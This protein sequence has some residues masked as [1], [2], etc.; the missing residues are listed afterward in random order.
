MSSSAWNVPGGNAPNEPEIV[1]GRVVSANIPRRELRIAPETSHPERFRELRVIRLKSTAGQIVSLQ[2]VGVRISKKTVIAHVR[3]DDEQQLAA[4]RGTL[5][6]VPCSERF[7]LPENEY[8]ID[9]LLG[10]TIRDT[11]G[12]VI[13]KLS[14]IW[15]TPAND[16]YQV[17]DDTGK[18]I[19]LPAIEEVII[20][21]D[22][23]HGEIVADISNLH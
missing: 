9:D 4:A 15:E 17:L 12:R 19:L 10:L 13:G 8:Y 16:I 22:I 6:V 3:S 20:R 11:Q 21:V 7:Q 5:V 1:I 18:E 2:V 23:E 14:A